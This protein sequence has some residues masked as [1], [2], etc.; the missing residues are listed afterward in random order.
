MVPAMGTPNRKPA[1]TLLVISKP[2]ETQSDTSLNI[3]VCVCLYVCVCVCV[4][5]CMCVRLW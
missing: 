2:R 5:V 3:C 1:W 4:C